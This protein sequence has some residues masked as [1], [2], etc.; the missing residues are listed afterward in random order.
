[1]VRIVKLKT[2]LLSLIPAVILIVMA[3][4]PWF[5]SI[6]GTESIFDAKFNNYDIDR[7]RYI[8]VYTDRQY[9]PQELEIEDQNHWREMYVKFDENDFPIISDKYKHGYLKAN[10]GY[11]PVENFK[12][13]NEKLAIFIRLGYKDKIS[14]SV[15][16]D[17]ENVYTLRVRTLLGY[18]VIISAERK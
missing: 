14:K 1:M 8:E 11:R 3:L 6:A 16:M 18:S 12:P 9:S 5:T 4:F 17:K 15:L 13:E 2:I 10:T 7:Q